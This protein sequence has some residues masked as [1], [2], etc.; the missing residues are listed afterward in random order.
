MSDIIIIPI[1][2][3]KPQYSVGLLGEQFTSEE[4]FATGN[5]QMFMRDKQIRMIEKRI[6][7]IEAALQRAGITFDDLPLVS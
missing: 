2:P 3:P 5:P 4:L 1:D 6:L 7:R